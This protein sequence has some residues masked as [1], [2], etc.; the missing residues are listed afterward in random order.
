MN[1]ISA[2]KKMISKFALSVLAIGFLLAG[3]G[4]LLF[5]LW[6]WVSNEVGDQMAAIYFGAGLLLAGML[7]FAARRIAHG[8]RSRHKHPRNGSNKSLLAAFLHGFEIATASR[9]RENS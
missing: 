2:A 3:L 5:A 4:F 7:L 6:I 8:T 1:M 9:D